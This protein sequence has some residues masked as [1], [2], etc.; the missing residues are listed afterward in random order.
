MNVLGGAADAMKQKAM[1]RRRRRSATRHPTPS[2]AA[3]PAAAGRS[4]RRSEKCLAP[5]R[6][7][8]KV[9]ART[10]KAGWEV[11]CGPGGPFPSLGRSCMDVCG[12]GLHRTA[13][14]CYSVP[15]HDAGTGGRGSRCWLHR[16]PFGPQS[17]WIQ[18]V[19]PPRLKI[20]P[21]VLLRSHVGYVCF[22]CLRASGVMSW[23]WGLGISGSIRS[24]RA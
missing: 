22:P 14:S 1:R 13:E 24:G 16:E 11:P 20:L 6:T 15:R 5:S 17:R 18:R 23:G 7:S 4:A 8:A 9:Q 21:S 3:S 12:R 2:S 10:A 19:R